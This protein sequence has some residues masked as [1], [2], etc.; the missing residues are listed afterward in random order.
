MTDIGTPGTSQPVL[1][2]DDSDDD[3]DAIKRALNKNGNIVNSILRCEDG[4]DALDYLQQQG[5]YADPGVAPRPGIILLDLNMPG[6][7]GRKFLAQIKGDDL[8]KRIPVL[9]MTTSNSQEDIDYCYDMG[10]NTYIQKPFDWVGFC[11]A[12]QRLKDHWL[13]IVV[14]PRH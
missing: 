7:D 6:M 8:L 1:I 13:E 12:I 11:K 5:R 9:V 14:L 3:F 2:I 4:Q 10:A